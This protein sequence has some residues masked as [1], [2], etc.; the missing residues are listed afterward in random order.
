MVALNLFSRNFV[1]IKQ[2]KK[3]RKLDT[4]RST[5]KHYTAMQ[6]VSFF[7]WLIVISLPM[8][9]SN[10][11]DKPLLHFDMEK[12]KVACTTQRQGFLVRNTLIWVWRRRHFGDTV[13]SAQCRQNFA[14]LT[15]TL[16]Y[17]DFG[18]TLQRKEESY[19][20]YCRTKRCPIY[21]L[22][23]K[24]GEVFWNNQWLKR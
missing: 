21:D 7:F 11:M 4:T 19:P 10:K 17:N 1:A 9:V 3:R 23:W 15:P 18:S 13:C 24:P 22:G 5:A 6:V 12:T 14:P 16:L 2:T 20:A 8:C